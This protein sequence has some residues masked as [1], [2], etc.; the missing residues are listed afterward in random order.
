MLYYIARRVAVAVGL[1]WFVATAVFLAIHLVPG[2]AAE[3]LLSQGG[4]APHPAAVAEL[5]EKLGLD[6]PLLRQYLAYLLGLLRGNLGAS[7]IDDHSVAAEI[8]LRLPRTLELIGAA[9]LLAILVGFPAGTLAAV[10]AGSVGDR[11][12]SALAGI[13]ISI[14]VFVVGTL[15]ILLFAQKL[16]WV[17]AGGYVPFARDPLL[18]L[19]VLAMPAATIAVGLAAVVFR[20]TRSAVLETLGRDHVRAAR[21]RGVAPRAIIMRHVVRNSL[22]PI[23]TVVALH[24]GTLLGGTVLIEYVFNWPGLSGYLVRAVELRDYPE[25]TGIVLTIS[26]LFV[27]LNLLVDLLYAVLDPR[28]R[29]A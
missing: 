17:P 18:H 13:G 19:L 22:T 27:L 1:V 29:H 23:V 26:V 6:A 7:L 3:M 21:A 16:R 25:V 10:R 11:L 8:A 20:M 5:R 12:L 15:A 4:V 14:P 9:A 28:V 2:D 24:L